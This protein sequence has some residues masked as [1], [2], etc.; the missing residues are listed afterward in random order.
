V[1]GPQALNPVLASAV[2]AAE[3]AY[4]RARLSSPEELEAV[5]RIGADGTPT[6]AVDTLVETAILEALER[7]PVNR[8]TRPERTR[9]LGCCARPLAPS[10]PASWSGPLYLHKRGHRRKSGAVQ[11]SFLPLTTVVHATVLQ[12]C[13]RA[14]SVKTGIDRQTL[15]RPRHACTLRNGRVRVSPRKVLRWHARPGPAV[16]SDPVRPRTQRAGP[17]RET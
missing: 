4:W 12:I 3:A 1:T 5:H 6:M 13:S 9:T 10:L 2:Q 14:N 8:A 7:Q 17:H 11:C 16:P 15:W